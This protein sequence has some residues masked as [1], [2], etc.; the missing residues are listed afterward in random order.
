MSY[1]V[2][3][4]ENIHVT[5]LGIPSNKSGHSHS[6]PPLKKAIIT[7]KKNLCVHILICFGIN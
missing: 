5:A 3:L 4:V 1:R 2:V 6:L 7:D